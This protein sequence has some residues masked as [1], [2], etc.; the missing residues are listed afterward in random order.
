[1]CHFSGNTAAM[2]PCGGLEPAQLSQ[3]ETQDTP[4]TCPQSVTGLPAY[5]T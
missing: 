3:G 2:Y 1:M 5:T 4:W